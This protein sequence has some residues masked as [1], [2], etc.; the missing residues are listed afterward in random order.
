MDLIDNAEKLTQIFGRWPSF[1]DAEVVRVVLDRTGAEGPTLETSIHVFDMS[2]EVDA[3]GFYVLQ[4][5]TLVTL[6]FS[7]VVLDQFAGFNQQNVLWDLTVSAIDPDKH[8]GRRLAVEMPTSYGLTA[9]F[10][11]VRGEVLDAQPFSPP[12]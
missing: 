10:E 9:Q 2:S 7:G 3:R 12:A 5:H 4:N 8:E 6:K 11:C 1:H